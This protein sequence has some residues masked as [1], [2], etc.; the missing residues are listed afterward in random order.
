MENS[1]VSETLIFEMQNTLFVYNSEGKQTCRPFIRPW[2]NITLESRVQFFANLNK[3]KDMPL[4]K[5]S[6]V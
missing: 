4:P 6:I 2:S 3:P 5:V 1:Q